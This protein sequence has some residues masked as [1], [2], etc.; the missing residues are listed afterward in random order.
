MTNRRSIGSA[1]LFTMVI[2]A[3]FNFRNVVNNYVAIGTLAAPIFLIATVIYFIPFTLVIAQFVSLNR[4]S[5]SGVYQWVKSSLGGRWSFF[6][7]FCYWFAEPV[8]LRLP[9]AHRARLRRLHDPRPRG[10]DGTV[11]DCA[12]VDRDLL[13]RHLR[14]HQRR[15]VDGTVTSSAPP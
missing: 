14:L 5:E 1:I 12:A 11:D 6:T 15:Q 10:G 2:A 13:H 9:A 7:A 8:L 3:V 4:T